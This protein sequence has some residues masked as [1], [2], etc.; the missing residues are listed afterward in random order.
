VTDLS[1]ETAVRIRS[2]SS[3]QLQAIL[4]A[5]DGEYTQEAVALA[6]QELARRPR[7]GTPTEDPRQ[8]EAPNAGKGAGWASLGALAAAGHVSKFLFKAWREADQDAMVAL[9]K[10]A[11]GIASS[12]ITYVLLVVFAIWLWRRRA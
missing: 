12:P 1:A 7:M 3:D 11:Q 2:Q 10:G 6:R 5:P 9:A 8:E 4:D